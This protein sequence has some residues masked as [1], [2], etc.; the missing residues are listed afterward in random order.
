MNPKFPGTNPAFKYNEKLFPAGHSEK[1]HY[2]KSRMEVWVILKGEAMITL[3]GME[4]PV[5]AGGSV[6]IPRFHRHGLRV[7]TTLPLQILEIWIY[8]QAEEEGL[9]DD[10]FLVEEGSNDG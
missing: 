10:C 2:H 7:G 9:E 4:F 6:T 5:E 3:E 1:I 8:P